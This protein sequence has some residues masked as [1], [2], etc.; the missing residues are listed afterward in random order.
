[1]LFA[2]LGAWGG[3]RICG[4]AMCPKY[5]YTVYAYSKLGTTMRDNSESPHD[6][7]KKGSCQSLRR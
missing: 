3:W 2:S 6:R 7:M 4:G 1:M 5:H